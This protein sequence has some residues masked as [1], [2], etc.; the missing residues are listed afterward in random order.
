LEG[1]VGPKHVGLVLL[2]KAEDLSIQARH[3]RA[4]SQPETDFAK[5][6]VTRSELVRV[7]RNYFMPHSL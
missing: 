3:I 2:G 7:Q 5:Q 4:G 1:L 6:P